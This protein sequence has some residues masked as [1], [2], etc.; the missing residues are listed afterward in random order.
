MFTNFLLFG[1]LSRGDREYYSVIR[2]L[3]GVKPNNI[4]LYKLAMVHRSASLL[5]DDGS[6]MNNERLEFLGDSVIG[7]IVSDYLFIEFPEAHE[8][9]LTQMRSRIV[10]RATLNALAKEIGID[11][12]L[13]ANGGGSSKHQHIYGDALEAVIGAMYLDKGYDFTNRYFINEVL[14]KKLDLDRLSHTE[15]DYKSRILEWSQKNKRDL[16]FD[17]HTDETS[18]SSM[19]RF[20]TSVMLDDEQIATGEGRSKKEA[21]QQGALKAIESEKITNYVPD[22]Y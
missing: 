15:T 12:Y 4:E 18:T 7:S 22:G 8:G 3:F 13:I 17:T 20:H 11:K 2:K 1:R 10:N 5:L 16:R 9:F 21:E 14:H 19:P 6:T